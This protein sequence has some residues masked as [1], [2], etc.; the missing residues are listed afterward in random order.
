MHQLCHCA[1]SKAREARTFG[2]SFRVRR[3]EKAFL[4]CVSVFDPNVERLC[5]EV[6]ELRSAAV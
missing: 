5:E 1:R 4:P 6:Q 2:F 3:S